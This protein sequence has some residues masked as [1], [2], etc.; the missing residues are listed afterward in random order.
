MLCEKYGAPGSN[1]NLGR[2]AYILMDYG[3]ISVSNSW[4]I[5]QELS[6]YRCLRWI[7]I[8]FEQAAKKT[9]PSDAGW[10]SSCY[11]R[12]SFAVLPE[13]PH[14]LNGSASTFPPF[15]GWICELRTMAKKQFSSSLLLT[16]GTMSVPDQDERLNNLF[17]YWRKTI[18]PTYYDQA[19]ALAHNVQKGIRRTVGRWIEII[20]WAENI[21][22]RC[23]IAIR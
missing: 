20:E 16:K 14:R 22:R 2:K 13:W 11:P 15:D 10:I 12:A 1:I 7:W 4:Y 17:A 6:K 21:Y 23:T 9:K 5:C 19:D 18:L 3:A 8:T